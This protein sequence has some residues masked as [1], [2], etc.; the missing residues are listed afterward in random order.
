MFGWLT[1]R[2]SWSPD[3]ASERLRHGF[4][5]AR[6]HV[7][8]RLDVADCPTLL[9]LP[10][11]LHA[12]EINVAGCANLRGLPERATCQ[13]LVLRGTNV[14][15]IPAGL[16]VSR[17]LDAEG[18]RRLTRFACQLRLLWL[19]LTN[20]ASLERVPDGITARRLD[21]P[22]CT[23][24]VEISPIAARSVEHLDV[25]GCTRLASLPDS[26][27]L[28]ET[29]NVA[30]CT[31]LQSLP[32]GLRVRSW[33]DVAGSALNGLPWSMRS[34]RV[35]WRGVQ[36]PDRV[37][38]DPESIT[39]DEILKEENLTL[40]RILLDRVGVEWFV[41][42]AQATSI[43]SDQDTG[44]E[45]RLLMIDFANGDDLVCLQVR[46]P[47][48]GHRYLLRVPPET[49]SCKQAA[50]WIAGFGSTEAYQPVRET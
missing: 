11:E 15:C 37:A 7:R 44:G 33:I 31:Q 49:R 28:L 40:R 24:L 43:D 20:C 27:E 39:V 2:V 30:G 47:S 22:G 34:V 21:L 32:D 3:A 46:C 45:R 35:L 42:Q 14:E 26:F 17:V 12:T 6:M 8:G 50:A 18:C 48:T 9:Y 29:L 19:D 38:F 36:I 25:S 1:S 41:N 23:S 4:P 16:E 10:R 13:G 5:P